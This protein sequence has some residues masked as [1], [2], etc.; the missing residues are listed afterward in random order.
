[1][2]KITSRI[3]LL[4]LRVVHSQTIRALHAA[5]FRT[6]FVNYVET[7]NMAAPPQPDLPHPAHIDHDSALARKF[8]K[9]VV[10]YF[11]CKIE[12]RLT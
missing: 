6:S 7:V 11:G 5:S 12:S 1:M 10:N 8:G 4:R 2:L 3:P 9:E